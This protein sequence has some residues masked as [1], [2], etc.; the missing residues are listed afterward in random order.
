M[1]A[2]ATK[3]QENTNIEHNGN[4]NVRNDWKCATVADAVSTAVAPSVS[5][6]ISISLGQSGQR[7]ILSQKQP[8]TRRANIKSQARKGNRL[9]LSE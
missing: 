8:A 4:N 9:E 3:V 7:P 2:R 6:Y 5:V 1:C